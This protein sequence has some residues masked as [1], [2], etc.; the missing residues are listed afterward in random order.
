MDIFKSLLVLIAV[1]GFKIFSQL[2]PGL[3]YALLLF[4]KISSIVLFLIPVILIVSTWS[5]YKK[6]QG[7]LPRI[8]YMLAVAIV[9]LDVSQGLVLI[10]ILLFLV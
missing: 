4:P 5:M 8:I 3:P 9:V 6:L 1:L 7:R 10:F 2:I